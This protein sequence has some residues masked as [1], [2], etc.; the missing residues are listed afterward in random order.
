MNKRTRLANLAAASLVTLLLAGCAVQWR[1]TEPARELAKAAE[2]PGSAYGGWRV[3]QQRCASCHGSAADGAGGAPN[4]L[5]RMQGLGPQRF[6]D[7]VLRRYEADMLPRGQGSAR[8]TLVDDIVERRRGTL[9]MPAW[10]GEPVVDA[11]VMD[12][13]AYLSARSEGRLPAGR[14]PAR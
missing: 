4:L 10:Q 9:A 5:L 1:N 11:H 14:P 8:E 13:Y 7:L 12:L 2:P 3:Y 6:V